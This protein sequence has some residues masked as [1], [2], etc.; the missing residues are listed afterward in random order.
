[1]WAP[2]ADMGSANGGSV[3]GADRAERTIDRIGRSQLASYKC[4]QTQHGPPTAA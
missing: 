2:A 1:M 4:T 3:R